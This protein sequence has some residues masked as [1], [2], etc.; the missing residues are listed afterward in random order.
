MDNNIICAIVTINNSNYGNRLQNYATQEILKKR[1]YNVLTIKNTGM[2]NK[3]KNVVNYVIRNIYHIF[4]KKDFDDGKERENKFEEFNKNINFLD[5]E[6]NWFNI[7]YFSNFDYYFVGSDQVWNPNYRMSEFDLL[8]FT[9]STNKVSFAASI[10]VNS[11]T[12][13]QCN[14][15]KDSLRKFKKISVREE[16]GLEI[17]KKFL[18]EKNI[19]VLIDPTMMISREDWDKIMKNPGINNEKKYILT[20]FLGEISKENLN[21]IQQYATENN[22]EIIN[23][24]DKSSR[25]YNSGPSEFLFLEKHAHL[26]C[27]DSFHS[28]VFGILYDIPFVVFDRNDKKLDNMNSRLN[29][30]LKKFKLENRRFYEGKKLNEYINHDYKCAYDILKREKEKVNQFLDDVFNK[31]I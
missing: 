2:M 31:K 24:L 21:V 23:I 20:Y 27:T 10:G 15:M 5:K 4:K 14:K 25:F 13:E 1:G 3:R 6:F 19:E 7:K 28:S 12:D 11:L 16:K 22:C 26:I 29:T 17:I 18:P 8:D 30:L 9:Q